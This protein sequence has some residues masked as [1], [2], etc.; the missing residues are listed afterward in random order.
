M[1]IVDWKTNEKKEALRLMYVFVEKGEGDRKAEG[2][3]EKMERGIGRKRD[4]GSG[5]RRIGRERS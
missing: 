2:E 3:G 5:G 1:K 4:G